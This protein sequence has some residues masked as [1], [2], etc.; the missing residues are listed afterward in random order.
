VEG[1]ERGLRFFLRAIQQHAD[2]RLIGMLAADTQD[3][4]QLFPMLRNEFP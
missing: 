4:A 2:M 1:L 3:N